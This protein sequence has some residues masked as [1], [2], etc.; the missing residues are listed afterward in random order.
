[1]KRQKPIRRF[2]I[3]RMN[4]NKEYKVLR[5]EYLKENEMCERCNKF[6]SEIHHKN[7][8]NGTRLVDVDYFMAVC[9]KC[10][11]YI[12]ANPTES[13]QEGWLI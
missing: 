13:R 1:M 11:N 7:G 6:A 2:S 5:K 12:H 3:K 9:R 4:Q 10:H 8:R